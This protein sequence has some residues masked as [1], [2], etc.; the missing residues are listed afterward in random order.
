[1]QRRFVKGVLAGSVVCGLIVSGSAAPVAANEPMTDGPEGEAS[2]NQPGSLTGETS[3]R[4]VDSSSLLDGRVFIGET[5]P[6]GKPADAKEEIVFQDGKFR[7]K[8][9]DPYGFGDASYSAA[10]NG[11]ITTFLAETLSNTDGRISW[12]GTVKGDALEG[13]F[14]WYAPGKAPKE[15]WV[16]G[17]VQQQG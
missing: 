16:K 13:T 7:S 4:G 6:D 12:M 17:R 11:D 9:C 3:H 2:L 14:T 1:M 5:G 15:Y 10:M 8:A